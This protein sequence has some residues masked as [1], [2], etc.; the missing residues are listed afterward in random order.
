[1]FK[2]IVKAETALTQDSATMPAAF[3]LLGASSHAWFLLR[4][5][6]SSNETVEISY[7]GVN[8][9][10]ALVAGETFNVNAQTNAT[11]TA[12]VALFPKNFQVWVRG[13][14]GAGTFYVIGY[15][16]DTVS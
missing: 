13:T 10:D 14:A 5:V 6:N 7:D 15:Y 2:N 4:F 8:L 1:M 11:P 3:T 12:N 9:N 16:Q